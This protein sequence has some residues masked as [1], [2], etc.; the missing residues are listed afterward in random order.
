[1]PLPSSDLVSPSDL[2]ELLQLPL[3]RVGGDA[4]EQL[5]GQLPDEE[6]VPVEEEIVW[7][8][9]VRKLQGHLAVLDERYRGR[10]KKVR[11]SL[12]DVLLVQL[13]PYGDATVDERARWIGVTPQAYLYAQ[14]QLAGIVESLRDRGF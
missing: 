2:D 13:L 3:T 14:K 5:I 10:G 11:A 9:Y 7:C 8:D 4:A 12:L 6:Q 1:M